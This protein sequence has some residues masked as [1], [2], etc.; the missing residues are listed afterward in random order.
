MHTLKR[1]LMEEWIAQR[2]NSPYVLEPYL[3]TC[4]RHYI[5]TEFIDGQTLSQ[6]VR[7]KPKPDIETV[8]GIVEQITKGLRAFHGLE[9]LHQDLRPANIM[10]DRTGTVKIIDF[11]S[12]RVAGISEITTPI[13]QNTLQGTAQYSA[14]EYFLGENGST[15][16]DLFSLGVITYQMLSGKRPYG[17][18]VA[19]AKTRAGQNKLKY[20]SVLNDERAIPAWVDDVL[21]KTLYPSTIKRYEELSEFTHDLRHPNKAFLNKDRPPLLERDPALF[22]EGVSFVFASLLLSYWL[23]PWTIKHP[24]NK[25]PT[26]I[27]RDAHSINP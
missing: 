3:Q 27:N 24:T 23:N 19:K 6:R 18:D 10:I 16:S 13:E 25:H 26:K 17:A 8:R 15:R 5:V 7:D 14:P 4:Q 11:G 20:R 9:M 21:R 1:F 22:W 12:T 2:I